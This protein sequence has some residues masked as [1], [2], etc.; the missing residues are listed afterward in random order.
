MKKTWQERAQRAQE[1]ADKIRLEK[2][3][4][5]QELAELEASQPSIEEMLKFVKDAAQERA[6]ASPP[7]YFLRDVQRLKRKRI[8]TFLG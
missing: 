5:D 4:V 1:E 7:R 2:A 3:A 8:S 6:S